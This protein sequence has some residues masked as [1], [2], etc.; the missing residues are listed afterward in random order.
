MRHVTK[1]IKAATARIIVP[2]MRPFYLKSTGKLSNAPPSML[3]RRV[4]I[5]DMDEFLEFADIYFIDIY[6]T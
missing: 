3:L 1:D 5:V 2:L 4:K 6:S